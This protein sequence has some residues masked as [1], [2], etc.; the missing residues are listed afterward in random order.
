MEVVVVETAALAVVTQHQ[1][2]LPLTMTVTAGAEIQRT[3]LAVVTQH[4]EGLPLTMMVTAGAE[5]QRTMLA[6]AVV[7]NQRMAPS[8]VVAGMR[9][10]VADSV[11]GETGTGKT[12]TLLTCWLAH[13][14]RHTQ[15]RACPRLRPRR[16]R[17]TNK[18]RPADTKGGPWNA[19]RSAEKLA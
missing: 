1:E 3:M 7:M 2:G 5:M 13:V 11:F 19:L 4:Q 6:E 17:R 12:L 14:V 16:I 8:V 15:R 9:A 18:T 10:K